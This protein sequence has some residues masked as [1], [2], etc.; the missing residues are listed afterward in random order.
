[1]NLGLRAAQKAGADLRCAGPE[2]KRRRDSTRVCNATRR[3]HRDAHGIHDGRQQREQ[4]DLLA[5]RRCCI[6][7]TAM[8]AGF[9]A[10]GHDHI[11]TGGHG[12]ARLRYRRNVGKPS[13]ALLLEPG[14]EFRRV[15]TH[16]GR[17][18]RWAR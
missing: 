2:S 11:G 6:E 10:L 16:D 13:D 14:D 8:P 3:N 17:D 9:R 4:S 12:S 1:M 7:A 18:D 5:L 15:K